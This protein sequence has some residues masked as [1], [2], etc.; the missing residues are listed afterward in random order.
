MWGKHGLKYT[1]NI[2]SDKTLQPP[3]D[4]TNVFMEII[5]INKHGLSIRGGGGGGGGEKKSRLVFTSMVH[6]ISGFNYRGVNKE[7]EL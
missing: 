2:H 6:L 7:T 4:T 5:K 3:P 1:F